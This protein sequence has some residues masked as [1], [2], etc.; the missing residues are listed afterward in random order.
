[1][2]TGSPLPTTPAPPRA[3]RSDSTAKIIYILYLIG[4]VTSG[5]TTLIGVIMA[6]V[7]VGEAPEPVRTHYRVQ[8]RTFWILLLYSALSALLTLVF[9]GFAL[10]LFVAVW[11]IVRCVKGLKYLDR[12]EAYPNAATWLW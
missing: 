10:L 2:E 11:L 9:V 12:G 3:A 8:I 6:Y 7:N 5:V 1:M 4:L